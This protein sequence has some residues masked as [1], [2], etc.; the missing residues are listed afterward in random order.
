MTNGNLDLPS[1][2]SVYATPSQCVCAC[3]VVTV[4][5]SMHLLRSLKKEL[6]VKSFF[7]TADAPGQPFFLL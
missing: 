6:H 4:L 1:I 7:E 2:G 3:R 5:S